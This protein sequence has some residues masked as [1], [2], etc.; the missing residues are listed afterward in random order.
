MY[1]IHNSPRLKLNVY[2][3][4]RYVN[5]VNIVLFAKTSID[6]AFQVFFFVSRK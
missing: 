2:K 6:A 3:Y 5:I 4:V 1:P